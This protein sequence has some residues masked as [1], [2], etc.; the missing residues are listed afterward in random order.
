MN[1]QALINDYE[2]GLYYKDNERNI[3]S[4]IICGKE[5][6]EYTKQEIENLVN[7]AVEFYN[8]E[9][10][11]L[12]EILIILKHTNNTKL[13]TYEL[14]TMSDKIILQNT[15]FETFLNIGLI[16]PLQ[17]MFTSGYYNKEDIFMKAVENGH[18]NIC[19]W[20]Y[21]MTGTNV[22]ENQ[23]KDDGKIIH[24]NDTAAFKISC[25]K[26]YTYVVHW[27]I[28]CR[29]FEERLRI[30]NMGFIFACENNHLD[31]AKL[32]YKSGADPSHSENYAFHISCK[33]GLLHIAK[34]LYSLN[35]VEDS[36]MI[37]VFKDVCLA[38]HLDMALWLH[39]KSKGVFMVIEHERFDLLALT[40]KEG[41][42]ELSKWIYNTYKTNIE[43]L[44]PNIYSNL[45]PQWN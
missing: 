45:N 25:K 19:K 26:G 18:L 38:G 5:D 17:H 36:D 10:I 40:L 34:W 29:W 35:I 1:V 41:H 16:T 9:D 37:F 28:N 33:M 32:L 23:S 20:I 4:H 14:R 22:Q 11:R 42:I 43:K 21:N 7:I 44:H 2:K 30:Y 15:L 13:L 27:L 39:R 12:F 3:N 31:L 24:I 6:S 8:Q